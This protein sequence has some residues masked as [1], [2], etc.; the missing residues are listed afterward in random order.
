MYLLTNENWERCPQIC[1]NSAAVVI[2]ALR[3]KFNN[4]IFSLHIFI[5]LNVCQAND[6][7]PKALVVV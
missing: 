4:L 1:H 3:V 6:F 7:I 5:F 2:D